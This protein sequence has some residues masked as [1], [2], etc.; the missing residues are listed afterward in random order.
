VLFRSRLSILPLVLDF[1]KPTPSIGYRDHY[2]IAADQRLKC[3][4][5]LALGLTRKLIEENHFNFDMIA[6]GL[7]AFSTHR[8]VVDFHVGAARLDE[9]IEALLATFSRV[10]KL[11]SDPTILVCEK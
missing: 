11:F 5:V 6:E 2:S 10:R 1:V 9:F 4:L 8:A 3:E 7:A